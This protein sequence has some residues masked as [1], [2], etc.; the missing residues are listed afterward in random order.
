MPFVTPTRLIQLAPAAAP[1]TVAALAAALDTA[2]P[3]FGID[4]LLE[5]AHF[6]AQAAHETAGFARFEENLHYTSPARLNGMFSSVHGEMDAAALIRQGPRAIASRV[7]ADRLGN[8]NEGSGDGWTFRGRGCFHLTGRANYAAAGKAL[9][10][11]YV[12][13]P[14]LVALPSG[15]VLTALWF[16]QS[17]G[18]GEAAG[19]DDAEAVTR[20]VNGPGLVGLDERRALTAR[21]KLIFV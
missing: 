2:M 15:A 10:H 9:G 20:I 11:D 17:H 21:A 14:D 4:T 5:R 6:L 7:Y 13:A 1:S 12:A 19:R 3:Q 16:W 18:C 8:G